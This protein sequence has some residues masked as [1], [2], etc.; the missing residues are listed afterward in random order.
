MS[1]CPI[2]LICS[3]FECDRAF[4]NFLAQPWPLPYRIVPPSFWLPMAHLLVKIPQLGDVPV[5]SLSVIETEI[6]NAGFF[7]PIKLPY[8]AHPEGGLLVTG[9]LELTEMVTFARPY[10]AYF[11]E[12]LK[13]WR[14]ESPHYWLGDQFMPALPLPESEYDYTRGYT[15]TWTPVLPDLQPGEFWEDCYLY[16][17]CRPG[18]R[19]E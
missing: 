6:W 18:E 3:D 16:Y 13:I 9:F 1:E 12:E 4:C 19:N 5:R 2:G 17:P 10:Y 7:D 8:Q 15:Q 14:D 11:D